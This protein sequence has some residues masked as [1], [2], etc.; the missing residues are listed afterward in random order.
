MSI[1][2]FTNKREEEIKQS[3]EKMEKI[4]YDFIGTKDEIIR[5]YTKLNE[6][7]KEIDLFRKQ[8]IEQSFEIKRA[9]SNFKANKFASSRKYLVLKESKD[10]LLNIAFVFLMILLSRVDSIQEIPK[11][12]L[13]L[14][15]VVILIIA[16]IV[17]NIISLFYI[18]K[19]EDEE[20]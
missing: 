6:V 16:R 11:I 13:I 15:T 12:T 2:K 18:S 14:F 9:I 5:T 8:M 1:E 17:L 10:I 20:E 3:T 7:N 4:S 19:I